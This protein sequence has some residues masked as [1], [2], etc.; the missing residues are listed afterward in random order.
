MK[1]EKISELTT[2][3]LS[4]YLRCL[5][6]LEAAG[7]ETIS[8]QA[9]AERFNL[10]SAQIRKDLAYFGEFGVRGV[11]Y[12]VPELRDHLRQILGLTTEHRIAIIGAGHL[13]M[14]LANYQGFNGTTFRIVALF[15]RDDAK[16]G[17]ESRM[18]LPVY[19]LDRFRDVVLAHNIDM[20]VIAVPAAAA[21]EALELVI[22]AGIRAIL[23]FAPVL[24]NGRPGIK[25]RHVDMSVSLESL[26]YF[27]AHPGSADNDEEEED[28]DEFTAFGQ[29]AIVNGL[30]EESSAGEAQHL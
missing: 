11:G 9:L 8:S 1:T 30:P 24:L 10:N 3:R 4:L 2:N 16:V 15:D 17:S 21:E 7:V 23:N 26:S 13:G 5:G 29:E 14:A 18:G 12:G 28:I 6:Q 19:S 25:I 20:G 27:L 22:G